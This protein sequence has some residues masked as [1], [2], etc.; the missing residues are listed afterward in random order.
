[1]LIILKSLPIPRSPLSFIPTYRNAQGTP[2]LKSDCHL[3]FTI[4][5]P[6]G[7]CLLLYLNVCLINPI[8]F[9]KYLFNELTNLTAIHTVFLHLCFFSRIPPLCLT[10]KPY[11][12]YL[13]H[14]SKS[15][16]FH[17]LPE[18]IPYVKYYFS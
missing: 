11:R 12:F 2:P 14:N 5:S 17:S 15:L 8:V 16:L 1:M 9:N 13:L 18:S 4:F 7:T 3:K 6:P 10:S